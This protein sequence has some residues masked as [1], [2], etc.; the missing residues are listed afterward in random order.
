M[1]RLS[2]VLSLFVDNWT[3]RFSGESCASSFKCLDR[4]V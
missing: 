1:L 4:F 2:S 3:V